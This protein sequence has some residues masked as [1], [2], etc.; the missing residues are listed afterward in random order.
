[1]GPST[2]ISDARESG[3]N[4]MQ[5]EGLGEDKEVARFV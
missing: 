1:V 4:D 2:G 3:V 5:A